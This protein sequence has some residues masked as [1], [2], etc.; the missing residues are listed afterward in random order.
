MQNGTVRPA[1]GDDLPRLAAIYNYYIEKTPITFD[2][3]PTTVAERRAWLETFGHDGPHR[4]FV[5]ETG[6]RVEGFASSHAFRAKAAYATTVET[7]VYLD[8]DAVGRALGT[9]LYAALFDAL[10]DADLHRAVAGITLPNEP[11]IALHDRF[12]FDRVGVFRE[13]GR[14]L[15]RYWDVLWME[16]SLAARRRNV[17]P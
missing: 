2:V 7:S 10:N 3:V 9:R 17:R 6:G 1:R 15:D 4:L 8:P 11:S 16:K 14:K 13:V 5:A 12:G